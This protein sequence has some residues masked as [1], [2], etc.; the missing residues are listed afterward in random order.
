MSFAPYEPPAFARD[1]RPAVIR[2]YR[3]YAAMMA[4]V[5]LGGAVAF[6]INDHVVAGGVAVAVGAFFGIATFVPFRPWGWTMGLVA[7]GLGL[8]GGTALFAIPLLVFWVKPTA[9]AAF[10]RL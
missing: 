3:F 8:A 4:L 2:W 5:S 10:A 7:I 6:S 9:K 1:A